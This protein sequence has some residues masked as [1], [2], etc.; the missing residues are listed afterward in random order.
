MCSPVSSLIGDHCPSPFQK[1][2]SSLQTIFQSRTISIL[3]SVSWIISPDSQLIDRAW[4]DMSAICD[5]E[6]PWLS[7]AS[8]CHSNSWT[9]SPRFLSSEAPHSTS[10][11]PSKWDFH[12]STLPCVSTKSDW[13]P[14][15][16]ESYLSAN[17]SINRAQLLGVI[18][19]CHNCCFGIWSN[20]RALQCL[21]S[22]RKVDL[23]TDY[24]KL[25]L[26]HFCLMTYD[27]HYLLWVLHQARL[28]VWTCFPQNFQSYSSYRCCCWN[29]HD[30]CVSCDLSRKNRCAG[31]WS[32]G[33]SYQSPP[34]LVTRRRP[35][36]GPRSDLGAPRFLPLLDIGSLLWSFAVG[37][38]GRT[39]HRSL[40][41]CGVRDV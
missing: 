23:A 37:V 26:D 20:W 17:S 40:V 15:R 18:S 1:Q 38:W 3:F 6:R 36:A 34:R 28:K 24:Q 39:G 29:F 4:S 33:V 25:Q 10:R 9:L 41:V 13:H 8:S 27:M 16:S 11:S 12:L 7:L 21:V 22:W 32:V 5:R 14:H 35:S 31:Q 2:L 30:C 19:N